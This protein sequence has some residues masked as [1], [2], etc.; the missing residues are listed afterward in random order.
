MRQ[1]LEGAPDLPAPRQTEVGPPAD[2]GRRLSTAHSL[3]A[4]DLFAQEPPTRTATM[5]RTLFVL[6]ILVPGIVLSLRSR[7]VAL[8]MYLWFALFRPQDWLWIDVTSLRLSLLLGLIL[9]VPAMLSGRFPNISHPLCIGMI[10]FVWSASITQTVAIRPDVGWVW[11]DFLVRL[12]LASMMIV[13]CAVDARQVLGVLA[14]I[15]GSLG[16]HAAKAGLA[17]VVGGGTRFADGLAGAFVDNNGYA[18]ATVMIIPLLLATA[19]NVDLIYSG[20]LL[21]WVRRGVYLSIPLCMFAVIGTYSR[22]GFISLAAATLI[23]AMLQDRRVPALGGLAL[24]VTIALLVVPIPQSYI[25]RLQT[26]QT[27]NEIGEESAMS[28]PHF[29]RVGLRMV[30]ANPL[31]VGLKQYEAAYDKYDFS[32]GRYGHHRAVHNSHV[33]VLAELGYPGELIWAGLFAFAFFACVRVRRRAREPDLDPRTGAFM[34][35]TAN[36]LIV[37][38]GAFVIGGS[39]LSLA[40]ND[41]TW[42]TFGLVAAL[43]RFAK[44]AVEIPEAAPV[45]LPAAPLLLGVPTLSGGR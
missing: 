29:W 43:D 3:S 17:Y 27:Y 1:S 33:Q 36:A 23:F 6:A 11:I 30:S 2:F 15:A 31:G 13:T 10:L 25:D 26:I 20:R 8:L 22:G 45:E 5:L 12:F 16:F 35:T 44:C 37:S 39:F 38:M 41:L 40:V 21:K 4:G 28:R 32:Y 34:R 18:L 42:L 9:L 14:V 24:V 19:Q 7:Y